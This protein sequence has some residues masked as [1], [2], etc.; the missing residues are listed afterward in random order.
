MPRSSRRGRRLPYRRSPGLPVEAFAEP[1]RAPSAPGPLIRV[2]Q[3]TMIR[4]LI[5]NGLAGDTLTFVL[6]RKHPG[7]YCCH[8]MR[9]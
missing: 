3:G 4:A 5:R 6:L 8:F 9:E 2:P 7:G 1:G